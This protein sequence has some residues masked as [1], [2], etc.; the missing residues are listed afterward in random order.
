MVLCLLIDDGLIVKIEVGV[1]GCLYFGVDVYFVVIDGIGFI[2]FGV[3]L[4]VLFGML[5]I[6]L[7]V[8]M[9]GYWNNFECIVEV[10]IDGWVNIGDLLECCEDGFFYI[11]GRF[12][13]MIIC[14]GVNIVFDE[15]DCIVE[16]V[17][18]VCEV[19]CYEIFDEEFGVLVGLVVVVLVEFDELVVWVFKYMIV[20]CF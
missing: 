12:L 20:V 19:V 8:N 3:G 2:V 18:G 16:G 10:L 7:L 4:F 5:W 13:E 17:L 14:G 15:V 9:L 6:K 11:K 1:V